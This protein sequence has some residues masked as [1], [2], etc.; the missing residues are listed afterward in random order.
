VLPIA[1]LPSIRY[2]CFDP[3]TPW[4]SID[5]TVISRVLRINRLSQFCRPPAA[6]LLVLQLYYDCCHSFTISLSILIR[7]KSCFPSCWISLFFFFYFFFMY[8]NFVIHTRLVAHK[9]VWIKC[10]VID[11]SSREYR[12]LKKHASRYKDTHV[13]INRIIGRPE[14]RLSS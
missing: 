1:L 11:R 9:S 7:L 4:I 10:H 12:K 5:S 6:S 13:L 14:S 2:D 8:Y 3:R